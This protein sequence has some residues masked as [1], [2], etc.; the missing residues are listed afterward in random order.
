MSD[1]EIKA[2]RAKLANRPRSDDYRQRRKDIDARGLQY[3]LA[4]DVVVE[5]VSANGVRAEWTSTPQ[6]DR[7]AALIYLHGGGY[8]IGSLDSHRHLVSET[9]RA[10]KIWALSLDYR[11]APEHAFPAAV[12][13]CRFRISLS[14]VQGLPTG[15]HCSRR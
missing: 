5:P 13:G 14:V 1:D 7:N 8:V 2:L 3:S 15:A 12:R 9:G 6:A 10:A 4:P 11:L